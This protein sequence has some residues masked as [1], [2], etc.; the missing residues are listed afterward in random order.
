MYVSIPRSGFWVF[1]LCLPV[2]S[3]ADHP[4]FNPSVGILGVQ[5]RD[6]ETANKALAHVSIPR[7]GFWVFKPRPCRPPPPHL[8]SFNPS[9]GILG[10]QA[11]VLLSLIKSYP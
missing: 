11:S 3:S 5:A 8:R 7:S 4:R 2:L 1:K 10:V 6:L 9:V